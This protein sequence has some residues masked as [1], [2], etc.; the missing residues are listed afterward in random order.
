M[1]SLS[2]LSIS[3]IY[4]SASAFNRGYRAVEDYK[5]YTV[6]TLDSTLD[7]KVNSSLS[8]L[9]PLH[10]FSSS[11]PLAPGEYVVK[12][13]KQVDVYVGGALRTSYLTFDYLGAISVNIG[14]PSRLVDIGS[15]LPVDILGAGVL[16][17]TF[18]GDRVECSLAPSLTLISDGSM[19]ALKSSEGNAAGTFVSTVVG[20]TPQHKLLSGYATVQHNAVSQVLNSSGTVASAGVQVLANGESAGVRLPSD[21]AV[22]KHEG[23]CNI[24]DSTGAVVNNQATHVISTGQHQGVKL[25]SDVALVK[26]G[27]IVT[28]PGLLGLPVS[29]KVNVL[30]GVLT[31]T[32]L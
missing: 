27:L 24:A 25:P 11:P 14:D 5:S 23:L 22:A 21:T 7:N 1:K 2:E 16:T 8:T 15:A 28:A 3:D 10:G 20:G 4:D 26:N 32:G 29:L 6:G 31:L 17:G 30:N 18:K 9:S 12:T 19:S 13:G